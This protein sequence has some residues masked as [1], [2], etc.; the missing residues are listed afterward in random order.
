MKGETMVILRSVLKL[1]RNHKFF[2]D[3]IPAVRIVRSLA[4][5]TASAVHPSGVFGHGFTKTIGPFERCEDVDFRG[6][7]RS[8]GSNTREVNADTV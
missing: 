2:T 6:K 8:N 3:A 7:G 4:V 5:S 1:S